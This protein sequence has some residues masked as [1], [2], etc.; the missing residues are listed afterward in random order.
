MIMKKSRKA[1]YNESAEQS[2]LIEWSKLYDGGWINDYLFS[3]PNGGTRKSKLEAYRLK[4]EGVEP[5]VSDLFFAFPCGSYCG[6]WIEMKQS[7]KNKS[8][9]TQSQKD[10]IERM[11]NVGYC[12]L[13]CYGWVD[14]KNRIL[15][16]LRKKTAKKT[17]T[18]NISND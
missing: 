12:G 17:L 3:I 8:K 1:S 10:W 5:G 13:V 9:I 15:E 2:A 16:Y 18:T 11:N 7:N 6:L 14:A 4:L